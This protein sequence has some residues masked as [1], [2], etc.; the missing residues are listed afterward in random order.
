M[1]MRVIDI[2]LYTQHSLA[3]A[4]VMATGRRPGFYTKG[5]VKYLHRCNG[6]DIKI[7]GSYPDIATGLAALRKNA[8]N[9][10]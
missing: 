8:S 1:A 9:H 3:I 2:H 7:A 6:K 4:M 10:A 5:G